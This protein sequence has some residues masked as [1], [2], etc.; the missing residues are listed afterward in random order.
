MIR[1]VIPHYFKAGANPT[2]GSG[3]E[4]V[5]LA[6]NVALLRC[7]HG[8]WGL[9]N[10]SQDLQLNL[11]KAEGE[12]LPPQ[13]LQ[14]GPLP[15]E[16]EIHVFVNRDDYLSEA[17]EL[18]QPSFQLHQLDLEDPRHLALKA[19]DFLIEHSQ[20]LDLNL[21][22]EDD[23][24][25][26]DRLLPEKILWMAECSDHKA[27]LF[28]HRYEMLRTPLREPKLFV[29]GI[30]DP[31][32]ICHWHEPSE[33]VAS[34]KFRG[35]LQVSFDKPLNP[36]AGFFGISREQLQVLALGPKLPEAGFIGPL[37]TAATYSFSKNFTILKPSWIH[38]E[39]LEVEHSH[40][41]FLGYLS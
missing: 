21:Y 17:L 31:D 5:C 16:V 28:P 7:L 25:I 3:R 29:D 33:N 36:H 22:L 6:R 2:Y 19:R 12:L 30:I 1:A 20:P 35:T 4:G 14:G 34:G 39:F 38:R 37:E 27:V 15:M 10:H 11:I 9:R 24:V 32:D 41:S 13:T 8:L 26:H 18:F 40:P 23:L